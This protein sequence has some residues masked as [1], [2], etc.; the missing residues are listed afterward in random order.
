MAAILCEGPLGGGGGWDGSGDSGC[1][2]SGC[3]NRTLASTALRDG[4]DGESQ[5]DR[6][7]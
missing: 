6:T 4:N 5:A 2:L 1:W 3:A 7:W